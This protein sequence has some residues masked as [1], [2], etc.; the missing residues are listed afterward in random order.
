MVFL[1]FT[2]QMV[3]SRPQN[4]PRCIWMKR[5]ITYLQ[6]WN[7]PVKNSSADSCNEGKR[8]GKKPKTGQIFP[9]MQCIYTLHVIVTVI[10]YMTLNFCLIYFV[11]TT[12]ML[13]KTSVQKFLDIFPY[14][15]QFLTAK[16]FLDLTSFKL[17]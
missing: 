2:L 3:F 11:K 10:H 4:L 16:K 7:F 9:C 15:F 8:G 6:M 5:N 12:V 14:I 1:P 13:Y 17:W